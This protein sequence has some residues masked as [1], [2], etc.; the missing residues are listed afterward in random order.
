MPSYFENT[1]D[2]CDRLTQM[3]RRA[4]N[5]NSK[6]TLG[7]AI[8]IIEHLAVELDDTKDELEFYERR[9]YAGEHYEKD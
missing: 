7:E 5:E 8:E 1:E 4:R 6:K 2:I 9:Y 3:Q